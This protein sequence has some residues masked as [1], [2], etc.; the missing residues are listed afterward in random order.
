MFDLEQQIRAWRSTAARD[1]RGQTNTLD[2]LENHLREAVESLVRSGS[3][4]QQA[5]ETA[6][7]R[8][9][10]TKQ[11]AAE[12]RKV[13]PL[14]ALSWL[15]FKVVVTL[16]VSFA[17]WLAWFIVS[18]LADRPGGALLAFHVFFLTVGY[19]A[20]FAVGAIAV[21]SIILRAV[22]GWTDNEQTSLRSAICW[23]TA[24]GLALTLLGFVLGGIWARGQWGHFWNWDAREFAAVALLFWNGLVLG[25]LAWRPRN[26]RLAMLLGLAGN[27]VVFACWFGPAILNTGLHSYGS[28]PTMLIG[29]LSA[30]LLLVAGVLTWLT[31]LPQASLGRR[32]AIPP[33]G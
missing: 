32:A 15:P 33:R 29:F 7:S 18:R 21:W 4:P 2:E 22:R 31:V 12:F 17:V 1:F 8:L 6:L 13:S 9:G 27:A 10:A 24:G 28:T 25:S 3:T 20:V 11:I 5:W 14:T 30:L 16:H 26:E 19:T 23:W